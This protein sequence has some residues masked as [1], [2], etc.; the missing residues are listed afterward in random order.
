MQTSG[1]GV[2]ARG[3]TFTR[4]IRYSSAPMRSQSRS[5]RARS[6]VARAMLSLCVVSA[7]G[8]IRNTHNTQR[9]AQ[10]L[11]ATLSL[12]GCNNVVFILVY[13]FGNYAWCC[14]TRGASATTGVHVPA[15]AAVRGMTDDIYPTPRGNC[16]KM[17]DP[18][19]TFTGGVGNVSKRACLT[20]PAS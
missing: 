17:G 1:I 12:I 15:A 19:Y 13:F 4:F 7:E 10:E 2:C 8:Y 14:I 16:Q 5:Q 3:G 18:M 11:S 9:R 6:N 20:S